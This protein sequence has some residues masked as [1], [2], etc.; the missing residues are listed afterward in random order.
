MARAFG[1]SNSYSY[2]K[3][4]P[5]FS[6]IISRLDIAYNSNINYSVQV[7]EVL[8]TGLITYVRSY[9]HTYI[10]TYI[11][12]HIHTY[13][14]KYIHTYMHT[15]IHRHTYTHTYIHTYTHTYIHKYIHTYILHTYIYIRTYVHTYIRT[16]TYIIHTYVRTYVRTYIHTNICTYIHTYKH[17]NAEVCE[18]V[19][20]YILD[21]L[22]RKYGSKDNISLYRDDGLAVLKNTRARSADRIR[23]NFSDTFEE[24]GLKITCQA[25][26]KIVN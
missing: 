24:E 18:L 6:L 20:L 17:T 5:N 1:A 23:K 10:R 3:K 11:H 16:Y 9:I 14:H 25:N 7:L 19:G 12:K 4:L 2:H 15:Y 26:M 22:T 13:T 21:K 8:A